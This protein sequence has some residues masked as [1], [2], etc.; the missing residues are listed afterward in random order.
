MKNKNNKSEILISKSETHRRVYDKK[1]MI[2]FAV[3]LGSLALLGAGCGK[4]NQTP[5]RSPISVWGVFDDAETM[6]PFLQGFTNTEV[7]GA[8]VDYKKKSPVDQYESELTNAL[9]E[10]RGPDVFLIHSSWLPRWKNRLLPAPVE[11]LPEKQVREAFVDEV[12]KNAISQGRVLALPLFMDS[13]A[14]YYNKDIFNAAGIARP[15]KTWLE[16]M[17]IVK[18]TTKFNPVEQNQ[19]DQH[20]ITMGAGK[21]VNRASDILSVL[22]MQNGV[23]ILDNE[24]IPSFSENADAVRALQFFTDF[25]NPNKDIYTWNQRSDYS[26][27]AFSEGEAAM[28][29]NYSY[30]MATIK[31]KNPRLNLGIAPLPQTETGNSDNPPKTYAG[32][33]LLGVSKQTT[34]PDVA[35]R[36]VKYMISTPQA[37]QYLEKSGY[38]PARRDLISELQSDARIGVFAGQALYA[39]SWPQVDNRLVDKLFTEAIDQVV[40]GQDTAEGAMRRAG[41]QLKAA[42]KAEKQKNSNLTNYQ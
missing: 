37:R 30:H 28:M 10:N 24:G 3:L 2:K 42:A 35:W 22:M 4:T 26:L 18:R 23:D 29:I 8:R 38:P 7:P 1:I 12:G 20:G 9:A 39:S 34:N 14:L 41:E 40:S 15:P 5:N 27:D 36:F 19:I 17:E 16:V 32:Y 21:N 33:W 25:A 11:L 6:R 31:G 13:L